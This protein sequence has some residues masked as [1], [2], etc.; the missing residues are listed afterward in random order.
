MKASEAKSQFLAN[1]SHEIRTPINGILGM[2]NMILKECRDESL[3]EYAKN[4]QSAGQSLLSIVNDILDISKI[5]SGKLEIIPIKYELFSVLNDCFNLTNAKLTEKPLKFELK[6]NDKLP[7][8]LYGDEVRIRQI[9]NNFLSNAIKYTKEGTITFGIDYEEHSDNQI[10]MVISVSD[11]GIGIKE[12]DL[13]KLFE[14][15]TRIEEKRNR[16]I[17]GTGLGLN[18]TK[19]LVDMMNGEIIVQSNYGEGSCFK[20]KIPQRVE[21]PAPIGDFEKRYQQYLSSSDCKSGTFLAPSARIL[22]VDDVEMNL[23]V[24][25]GLLKET[26]MH[27]DTANSGRKCLECVAKQHYDLIFLDH[28][29]PEMDGIET[30]NNLKMITDSPNTEVPVIMLTANAIAGAKE[31]YMAAGFSDYLAKPIQE[32]ELLEM[33]L[34]YLP[35]ELTCQNNETPDCSKEKAEEECIIE[36]DAVQEADD[37]KEG[38]LYHLEKVEGLDITCGLSYC[39]NDESFYNEMLSEYLKSDKSSQLEDYFEDNDWDNYRIVV[40]ALKST[41]LLIG[42]V[43]LSEAAKALEMAAKDDDIAY[44][45][46][47]HKAVISEYVKLMD[48]L[49]SIISIDT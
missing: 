33:L 16:N 32:A 30:L 26:Q 6:I 49:K 10:I 8:V 9:I 15:F 43:H 34:K 41:S 14:S 47:N 31:E 11:T 17:E 12:E 46:S 21:N 2:D 48:R 40:H 7:S 20:A 13:G 45:K 44:I 18:L 35:A 36:F 28:M 27:I 23:K 29:M 1:M 5:E 3:R 37:V 39:M 24:V 38:S 4:I 19:Q 22:V 42:A 25:K